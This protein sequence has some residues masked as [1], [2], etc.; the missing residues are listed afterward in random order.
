M[1]GANEVSASARSTASARSA[2]TSLAVARRRD[3]VWQKR[4]L[5]STLDG[6]GDLALMAPASTTGAGR[7]DLAPIADE[8]AQRSK[9]LVI[10]LVYLLFAEVAVAASS[11]IEQAALSLFAPRLGLGVCHPWSLLGLRRMC[12]SP[13]ERLY[14]PR[15][16]RA[17]QA[18]VV[19]RG[20]TQPQVT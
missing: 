17:L 5:A 3:H 10:D 2:T 1:V 13:V 16:V 4:H 15:F 14:H 7:L 18:D 11:L 6:D 8:A 9:I 20:V 12:L 19:W